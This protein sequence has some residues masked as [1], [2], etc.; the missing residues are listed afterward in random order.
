MLVTSFEKQYFASSGYCGKMTK[1]LE[2]FRKARLPVMMLEVQV[3]GLVG[4]LFKQFL[5]SAE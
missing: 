1:V 4:R 5:T 3:E 2:I